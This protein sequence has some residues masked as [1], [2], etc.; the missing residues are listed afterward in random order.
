[1][2]GGTDQRSAVAAGVGLSSVLTLSP[3]CI[4]S[5]WRVSCL[6]SLLGF[7]LFLPRS[8]W[9]CQGLNLRPSTRS[10]EDHKN[11]NSPIS[12]GSLVIKMQ[13][14]QGASREETRCSVVGIGGR[15]MASPLVNTQVSTVPDSLMRYESHLVLGYRIVFWAFWGPQNNSNKSMQLILSPTG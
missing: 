3:L 11:C 14:L 7:R 2:G 12:V 1:M 15:N 8:T 6:H 5:P 4:P 10:T 13:V 9:R